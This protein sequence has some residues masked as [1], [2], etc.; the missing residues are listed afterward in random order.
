MQTNAVL[1]PAA[2]AK[3]PAEEKVEPVASAVEPAPVPKQSI[4]VVEPQTKTL[5]GVNGKEREEGAVKANAPT[6]V[7]ERPEIKSLYA[8]QREG[9]R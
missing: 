9:F 6:T 3:A 4:T 2:P 1:V 5:P 8:Q 7:A